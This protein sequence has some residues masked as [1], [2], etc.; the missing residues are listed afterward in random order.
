MSVVE[1]AK[2]VGKYIYVCL[3][4]MLFVYSLYCCYISTLHLAIK[5]NVKYK[6]R[7][8]SPIS[9]LFKA[10]ETENQNS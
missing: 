5:V 6:R 10:K 9:G 2:M 1:L 4:T 3:F 8:R 7:R